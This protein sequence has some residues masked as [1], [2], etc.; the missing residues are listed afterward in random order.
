MRG[1]NVV[2]AASLFATTSVPVVMT[3]AVAGPEKVAF[4]NYQ[5]HVLYDVLDQSE[6]KE[7]RELYVNPEALENI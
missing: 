7:I 6:S 1:L 3:L 5:T 2:V 4:P